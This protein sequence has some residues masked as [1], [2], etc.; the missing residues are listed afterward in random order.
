MKKGA[1]MELTLHGSERILGR[2]RMLTKDVLALISHSAV[3]ALGARG[4][5]EYLLFYSPSEQTTKIAVVAEERSCLISIW[6]KH[7]RLP[8]GVRR[9][10]GKD[11]REARRALRTYLFSTMTSSK[12]IKVK[13]HNEG[14]V[15]RIQ[16]Q[17][18]CKKLYE[19]DAVHIPQN[20][21][22]KAKKVLDYLTEHMEQLAAVVEAHRFH[23]Q[24]KI[25]Y[26]IFLL[27]PRN[28]RSVKQHVLSHEDAVDRF[29]AA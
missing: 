14:F 27:D 24:G 10:Q 6:E 2:T 23:L 9:P 5:Y 28:P 4:P 19:D 20:V 25:R 22:K 11:E 29:L 1:V 17:L 15:A 21:G 8:E 18:D 7:F 3:V 13:A 16:V 26:V 12:R